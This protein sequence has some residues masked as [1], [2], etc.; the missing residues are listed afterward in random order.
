MKMT[1]LPTWWTAEEADTVIAFLDDLRDSLLDQ[2]G[3]EIVAMRQAT[4]TGCDD[5]Q[6]ELEF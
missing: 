4:D 3:E 1:R 6:G 2:Y 5:E